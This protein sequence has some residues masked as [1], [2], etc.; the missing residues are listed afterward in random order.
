MLARL[1]TAFFYA[2]FALSVLAAAIPHDSPPTQTVTVT[3]A[4]AST[5]AGDCNTGD[6][7][8]CEQVQSVSYQFEFQLFH[9]LIGAPQASS[10]GASELLGLLGIVLSDLDVLL[11]INCTP[12]N[13]IG[14]GS[15]ASCTASP[16]CC[17]NNAIVR[18]LSS[19]EIQPLTISHYHRVGWFPSA[20]SPSP[21]RTR[22]TIVDDEGLIH[23]PAISEI[24]GLPHVVIARRVSYTIML[25][26]T[27]A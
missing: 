8:C 25:L 26:E 18:H 7:Q 12:I 14:L 3:A 22:R 2:L 9:A 11:G 13:I 23:E 16:V 27:I 5:A 15:G 20:A 17:S 24:L 1:Q 21:C 6:I 4:P 19:S 10:G